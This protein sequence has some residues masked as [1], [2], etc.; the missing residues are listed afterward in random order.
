M[1]ILDHTNPDE[2]DSRYDIV[3]ESDLLT[4]VDQIE[5]FLQSVDQKLTKHKKMAL[6][7]RAITCKLID[8]IVVPKARLELACP[9]RH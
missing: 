4:T 1:V 6:K 8:F 2:M 3:D 7:K 5:V 9:Y